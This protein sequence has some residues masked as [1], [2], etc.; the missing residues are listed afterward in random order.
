M[1]GIYYRIDGSLYCNETTFVK[2]FYRLKKQGL[3]EFEATEYEEIKSMAWSD[4]DSKRWIYDPRLKDTSGSFVCSIYPDAVE[5]D[6][7][8]IEDIAKRELLISNEMILSRKDFWIRDSDFDRRI[9]Q[10]AIRN[11]VSFPE[12][13]YLLDQ[14][15]RITYEND[16]YYLSKELGSY[17]YEHSIKEFC[18][19]DSRFYYDDNRIYYGGFVSV[20]DNGRVDRHN[21]DKHKFSDDEWICHDCEEDI[22]SFKVNPFARDI[23]EAARA[24]RLRSQNRQ[25]FEATHRLSEMEALKLENEQLKKSLQSLEKA[26]GVVSYDYETLRARMDPLRAELKI[27]QRTMIRMVRFHLRE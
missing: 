4:R 5:T 22:G 20:R 24:M 25:R 16:V 14:G 12:Y 9:L 7:D 26:L 17:A 19:S 13:S 21:C 8:D 10:E 23:A 6:D 1:D 2:L 27:V 11:I 15:E 18:K 3:V